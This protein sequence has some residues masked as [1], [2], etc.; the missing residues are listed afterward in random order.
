[1][2]STLP[3][4]ASLAAANKRIG[5]ILKK[6]EDAVAKV[7]SALLTEPAEKVLA[8]VVDRVRPDVAARFAAND[9]AGSLKVLAQAREP[10]DAFFNDVMVM[11]EDPKV[12]GNRVALLREL[13]GL[14]NQ[15]A[16]ISKLAA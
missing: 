3:E 1:E 8:G 5:N 6:A 15:V 14:M 12:R 16:D 11:A 7:D 13:H 10:V 4:A 9:Y 2:F